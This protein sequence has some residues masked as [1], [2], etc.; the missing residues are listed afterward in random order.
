MAQVTPRDGLG[1][2][3]SRLII[4]VA[5]DIRGPMVDNS[6]RYRSI[7]EYSRLSRYPDCAADAG[8][9]WVAQ[10]GIGFMGSVTWNVVT[11]ECLGLDSSGLGQGQGNCISQ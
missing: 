4:P 5:K 3:I 11:L 8:P 9:E 1:V 10:I 2:I 7:A 6:I